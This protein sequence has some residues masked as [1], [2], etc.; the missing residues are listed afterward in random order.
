MKSTATREVMTQRAGTHAIFNL[1]SANNSQ[2]KDAAIETS[3]WAATNLLCTLGMY[4]KRTPKLH[5]YILQTVWQQ[6]GLVP[7]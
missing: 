6:Y 3:A 2:S 1:K 4:T 7:H 5:Y